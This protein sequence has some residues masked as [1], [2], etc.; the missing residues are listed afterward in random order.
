MPKITW[1]SMFL[2]FYTRVS[3]LSARETVVNKKHKNLCV[4]EAYIVV[5]DIENGGYK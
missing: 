5:E 1:T 2:F 4:C 3:V